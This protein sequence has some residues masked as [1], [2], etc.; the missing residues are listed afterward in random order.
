VASLLRITLDEAEIALRNLYE[1]HG[2]IMRFLA[3][4]GVP[5]PRTLAVAA[6]VVINAHLRR[7]LASER[8][9]AREV[10][11]RLEAAAVEKITLDTPTLA[12][13]AR[14]TLERMAEEF[15]DAP[16]RLETLVRLRSKVRVA[17]ALP[18]EVDLWKVQ[19][20]Y[21]RLM[22]TLLGKPHSREWLDEM[23]ALGDDLSIR[24]PE[25]P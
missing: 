7:A 20:L 14:R 22:K 24:I 17:N 4:L 12:F 1:H 16:D 6:E 25:R 5:A 21:F 9:E 18:F 23:L 3:D 2:T 8:A 11:D 15:F 19:N 13:T 10:R